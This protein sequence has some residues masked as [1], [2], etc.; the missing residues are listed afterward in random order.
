MPRQVPANA[1]S[2][3][4]STNDR[5]LASWRAQ[6]AWRHPE[7]WVITLSAIAWLFFI[8]TSVVSAG[9][10]PAHAHDVADQL[11]WP[12][13]AVDAGV[14]MLMIVAMMLPL[15]AGPIRTT[16]TRSLWRRRHRAICVFLV[17]YVTVWAIV[18]AAIAVAAIT[19]RAHV[20]WVAA[21]SAGFFVA[22]LWHGALPR[23]RAL[24]SCHRTSPLAP[25]G[26]RADADCLRFGCMI[27][28]RCV[29]SC[30][31]LMLACVLA[32]HSMV[33]ML[34]TS[35]IMVTERY[36]HRPDV[37]RAR[38]ALVVIGVGYAVA[39]TG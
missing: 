16:A 7:W 19:L 38:V 10:G 32:G 21:G 2:G 1:V 17:G 9:G 14:W 8:A 30:W 4:S 6:V 37:D 5:G 23:R 18:G 26:W 15:V 11:M 34:A 29:V 33:A 25:T 36:S 12:A 24:A 35:V 39:A 31:A 13:I 28:G 3:G 20:T 27:G 22:A